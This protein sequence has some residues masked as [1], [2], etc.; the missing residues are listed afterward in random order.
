MLNWKTPKEGVRAL[1]SAARVQEDGGKIRAEQDGLDRRSG[2][3]TYGLVSVFS[4]SLGPRPPRGTKHL[5]KASTCHLP[6]YKCL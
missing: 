6:V 3:P 4:A 5:P 1:A 2:A